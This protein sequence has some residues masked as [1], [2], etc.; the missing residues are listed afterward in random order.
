MIPYILELDHRLFLLINQG[1]GRPWLDAVMVPLSWMGAWTVALVAI[2]ILSDG[3]RRRFWRAHFPALLLGGLMALSFNG[4]MKKVVARSRPAAYFEHAPG[5]EVAIRK[6][7]RKTRRHKSFPSG[8]SATA[9][10]FMTY[11]ALYR[12]SCRAWV[13]TLAALIALSRVY[14]GQ[15]FP[16]DCVAGAVVGAVAAW[17]SWLIYRKRFLPRVERQE[18]LTPSP[19]SA[20]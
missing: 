6:V 3:G 9:F 1:L 4:Q 10:F 15:H 8:H 5:G 17:F 2:A 7:E 12:R 16:S 14:V 19:R 11:A 18:A 20:E 13:L